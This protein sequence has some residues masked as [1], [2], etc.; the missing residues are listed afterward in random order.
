[1][2]PARGQVAAPGLM[3]ASLE[4]FRDG[5]IADALAM[6]RR[7]LD[8]LP[9]NAIGT[10]RL[11]SPNVPRWNGEHVRRLVVLWPL[12]P[13]L[14][15]TGAGDAF[16]FSRY[17][18]EVRKRCCHLTVLVPA[19]VQP[20][21]G[22]CVPVDEFRNPSE[23][24]TALRSADAYSVLWLALPVALGCGFGTPLP[25][26]PL[27]DLAPTLAPGVRHVGLCWAASQEF[28]AA[29]SIRPPR[30]FDALQAL[31]G[32]QFHC[33]QAWPF[34]YEARPWMVKHKLGTWDD[35]TALIARLDAAVVVDTAC[36]HLAGSLG[37][38][39]H[40]VLTASEDW[41]W[42][43]HSATPWYPSSMRMHRGDPVKNFCDAAS[44]LAAGLEPTPRVRVDLPIVQP[45]S[46]G[47]LP[48]AAA[49]RYMGS[50]DRQALLALVRGARRVLE[51]GVQE[52]DSA[53][54]LLA[55]LPDIE[56]YEG[57]DVL[58]GYRFTRTDQASEVPSAPGARA[59]RDP[60]FRLLLRARGAFD[61]TAADLTR[62]DAVF[63]DGDHGREAVLHDTELARSVIRT[64]GVIVW[65]DFAN[66]STPDVRQ[67]LNEM[68][69][70][71]HD[72]QKVAGTWIAFER[73]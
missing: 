25:I 39:T 64:G 12:A 31:P 13:E 67:A 7:A 24:L 37:I 27:Q 57:V 1:M 9:P 52:G 48:A 15:G 26:E 46:I 71:G 72:I 63:I 17:L 73:C 6:H 3:H 10:P 34:H 58:R 20:I 49:S 55:A 42:G 61:L 2:T 32:V 8:D 19:A 53:A 45:S 69:A 23:M 70:A 35:T 11:I 47:A 14:A 22:R 59:A 29:R 18:T 62:C 54:F 65:H 21:I 66:P 16:L 60:R 50:A 5:Q 33:L 56:G 28:G 41:R 40:L 30:Q 68:R 36:A 44:A 51:I 4:L 43:Q 38:P